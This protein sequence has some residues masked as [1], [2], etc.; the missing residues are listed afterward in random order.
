[1]T[2]DDTFAENWHVARRHVPEAK[3]SETSRGIIPVR[4]PENS[5]SP[6]G[7]IVLFQPP[8]RPICRPMEPWKALRST[9]RRRP[10]F[11]PRS[12]SVFPL[13]ATSS[14]ARCT[15]PAPHLHQ[16][17]SWLHARIPWVV[18]V[19]CE[20]MQQC[21]LVSNRRARLAE[22][23]SRFK[24]SIFEYVILAGSQRSPYIC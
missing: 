12:R 2:P 15:S 4:A 23:E 16:H 7:P 5:W 21:H 8:V 20:S 17:L 1:M 3:E 19:L 9:A 6:S 22:L 18:D 14:L 10:H 13:A 11:L 24:R